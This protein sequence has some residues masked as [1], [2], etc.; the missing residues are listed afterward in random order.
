M[1][2]PPLAPISDVGSPF[3]AGTRFDLGPLGYTGAEYVFT[4]NAVSY[5]PTRAGVAVVE[6]ADFAT[7]LLVY[8]PTDDDAFNG[9]VWVEWL[10]VSGGLDASPDWIF[11][12]TELMR[13]GA[14]WVGVSAQKIGV[15]GGGSLIGLPS[16]GLVGTDPARYG[17]LRHPGDRF[18]Y[19]I[20]SQ[21]G[22]AVRTGSGTILDGLAVERV[23]AIGE[24]QSAF[25]LTTY[26]NEIDPVTTVYDGFL[27]HARG[28]SAAPLDDDEDP[29]A[30]TRGAPVTF[31]DDL[32]VPVLCVESETDLMNLGYLAARQDDGDAFVLWEIAGTSHGDIYT[33]VAGPIDTGRLPLADLAAAWVPVSEVY[34]M[35]LDRPVNA[36]PQHYVMNAAVS[37]LERWVDEGSRPAAAPRLEVSDGT[38]VTDENGNAKGGIRTPHVDVPTAVLSGLGNSGHPIAFLCGSSTPFDAETLRSLYASREDY[39]GR[40]T[41]ATEAAVVNGFVLEDDA[42]EMTAIATVN[43]PL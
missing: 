35:G 12:H 10:N 19:D 37:R 17:A 22:A 34:G 32:R 27:V 6:N 39:I 28:R 13:R 40:F 18:S 30:A 31:H 16:H 29:A 42:H 24:S 26:V 11:T 25:R 23:M 1:V 36:G 21:A 38:F 15:E 2:R 33:F 43:A 5:A 20:Y 3:I 8:R 7:R 14:A 9:T 41:A 4:G